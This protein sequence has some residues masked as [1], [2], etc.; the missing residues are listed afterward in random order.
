MRTSTGIA[1]QECTYN[2]IFRVKRM[3]Y[4][5]RL[6]AAA[7]PGVVRDVIC[8]WQNAWLGYSGG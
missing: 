5:F 3:G 1:A 2:D 8:R 7:R 4:Y 6:V